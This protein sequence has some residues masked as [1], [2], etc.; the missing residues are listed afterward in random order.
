MI[1]E[2]FR[3][4]VQYNDFKG[5]VSADRADRN[6]PEEFLKGRRLMKDEEFVLGIDLWAGENPGKHQDPVTVHFLL[7]Q[8]GFDTVHAQVSASSAPFKVRRISVDI[9]IA[10]FMGLFKRVSICLSPDGMLTDKSY[11][12]PE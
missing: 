4:S 11:S 5:T 12:Y 7:A 8:G 2:R 10:E 3:A 6:G 1:E 9:P